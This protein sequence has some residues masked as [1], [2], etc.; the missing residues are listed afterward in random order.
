MLKI[1]LIRVKY[2]CGVSQSCKTLEKQ[3]CSFSLIVRKGELF[4]PDTCKH[5]SHELQRSS[6]CLKRVH[7][8]RIDNIQSRCSGKIFPGAFDR[9]AFKVC[10]VNADF[11]SLL[12]LMITE[13]RKIP[14]ARC[15]YI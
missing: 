1:N 10:F 7:F 2:K 9:I 4:L 14:S 5:P 6:A 8:H 13:M 11:H 15:S 3:K 12:L